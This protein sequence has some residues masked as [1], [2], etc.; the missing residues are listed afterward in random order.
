MPEEGKR[1]A[2]VTGSCELPY[3]IIGNSVTLKEWY[4]LLNVETSLHPLNIVFYG[5]E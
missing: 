2:G 5:K 3:K 4:L 1:Q